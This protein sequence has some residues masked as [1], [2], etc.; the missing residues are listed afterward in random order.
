LVCT[1]FRQGHFLKIQELKIM[2]ISPINF[3]G[4]TEYLH[5][6]GRTKQERYKDLD[7]ELRAAYFARKEGV[8]AP[9]YQGAMTKPGE[10]VKVKYQLEGEVANT[11]INPITKA[12]IENLLQNFYLMDRAGF[13]HKNLFAPNILYS[14]NGK[15]QFAS[16]RDMVSFQQTGDKF[17]YKSEDTL[18]YTMPSNAEKFEAQN[19]CRYVHNLKDDDRERAF[20][21]TYLKEKS[22]Y[23]K[24]RADVLAQRGFKST[25]KAVMYETVQRDVFKEPSADVLDYMKDKLEISRI[26]SNANIMWHKSGGYFDGQTNPKERFASVIMMLEGLKKAAVLRDKAEELSKTSNTP[27]ERQYFAFE[28]EILSL[29][30]KNICEDT[31]TGGRDNFCNKD[32]AKSKGLFLGCKEDLALFDEFFDKIDVEDDA[33][34]LSKAADTVIEFYRNLAKDWSLETNR[35]YKIQYLQHS[36]GV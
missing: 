2:H 22:D 13:I 29:W 21:E 4:R 31:K 26:R 7:T 5:A 28:K 16:M 17:T 9:N 33:E 23:H 11:K 36:V 24:F 8:S 6:Q 35:A 25:D 32:F 30:T 14:D 34:T 19:L 20:L 1:L 18:D 27:E 10:S 15:I 12:H 3:C